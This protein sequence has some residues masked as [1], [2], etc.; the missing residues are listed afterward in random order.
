M[1]VVGKHKNERVSIHNVAIWVV[2]MK[3]LVKSCLITYNIDLFMII[4]QTIGI[5]SALRWPGT[6]R[7]TSHIIS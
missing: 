2:V 6:I 4:H 5:G 1:V 3:V 7:V